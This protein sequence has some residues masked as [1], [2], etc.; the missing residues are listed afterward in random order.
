MGRSSENWKD[1]MLWNPERWMN[2]SED[3]EEIGLK[4]GNNFRAW[5]P[6]GVGQR[7]CVGMRMSLVYFCNPQLTNFS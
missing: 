7:S 5:V 4:N 6:F 3:D 2:V 1:P